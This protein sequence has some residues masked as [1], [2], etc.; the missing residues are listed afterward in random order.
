M[1]YMWHYV[2]SSYISSVGYTC[3]LHC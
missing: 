3:W 1:H 2:N